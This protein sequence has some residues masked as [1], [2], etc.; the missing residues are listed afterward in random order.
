MYSCDYRTPNHTVEIFK[1]GVKDISV[2]LEESLDTVEL[3][4]YHPNGRLYCIVPYSNNIVNG[5][6]REYDDKG[7]P[8]NKRVYLDDRIILMDSYYY[9]NLGRDSMMITYRRLNDTL[10]RPRDYLRFEG[11]SINGAESYG[12]KV[13]PQKDT[14]SI[15]ESYNFKL[16]LY[17]MNRDSVFHEVLIGSTDVD[18]NLL[19]TLLWKSGWNQEYDFT[20]NPRKLGYNFLSGKIKTIALQPEIK[21][22]GL[23]SAFFYTDFYVKE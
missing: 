9:D 13:Y 18:M 16:K 14:I 21:N 8:V 20:F 3:R 23:D 2:V 6:I 10:L 1:N 17:T 12:M 19:D 4:S 7:R 15:N 22:I 5:V 11:D